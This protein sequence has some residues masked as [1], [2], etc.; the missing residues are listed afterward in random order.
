MKAIRLLPALCAASLL[1]ACA[2]APPPR[3]P[4]VEDPA[5]RTA[6]EAAQRAREQALSADAE[7]SLSGRIAASNAGRG[8]S[9]RL[10]W[11]QRGD[12][13][14]VSVSAPVT[15]QGWRLSGGP[16]GAVLEGVEGGPRQGPDAH[17]LLLATTGWD[18]PVRAFPSWMRGLREPALGA[19]RIEYG[20]DGL[21]RFM[22]QGGWHIQYHWPA[23][24][25]DG[26]PAGQVL[27]RRIEASRGEARVRLVVDEWVGIDG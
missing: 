3:A 11:Q 6:Y 4:A 24:P 22:E 9:G 15:R 18:V 5:L 16:G 14:E 23:G 8:G 26:A 25:E 7:W 10:D 2:S 13:F 1:A 17:T 20:T 12:G 19:A 21:P 27:P